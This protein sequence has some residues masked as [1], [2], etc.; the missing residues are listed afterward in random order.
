MVSAQATTRK[1][2]DHVKGR[3]PLW[4]ISGHLQCKMACPLYPQKRTSGARSE[5]LLGANSGQRIFA[6]M[7]HLRVTCLCGA[8]YE[9]IENEGPLKDQRPSKCVLC[10][11]E[12]FPPDSGFALHRTRR[13]SGRG[14][15]ATA[16]VSIFSTFL[17][18]TAPRR[19]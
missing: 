1:G 16:F 9:A 6:P 10:D 17:A 7:A 12:L 8:I 13:G 14:Q 18:D 5:C 15:G 2:V 4:V 3:C 11:R 19:R